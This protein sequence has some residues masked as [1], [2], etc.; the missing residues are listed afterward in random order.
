MCASR[1]RR[2]PSASYIAAVRSRTVTGK[3][4]ERGVLI[5]SHLASRARVT[6]TACS[7]ER[8]TRGIMWVIFDHLRP[9]GHIR[10]DHAGDRGAVFLVLALHDHL[11]IKH[12]SASRHGGSLCPRQRI[13]LRWEG[14]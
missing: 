1:M 4:R 9:P 12:E 7:P 6:V 14:W 8:T 10:P 3:R 5:A 2:A 13:S 11:H